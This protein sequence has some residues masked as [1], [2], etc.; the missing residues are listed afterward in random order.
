M[1]NRCDESQGKNGNGP[2]SLHQLLFLMC[3]CSHHYDIW[4]SYYGNHYS[5]PLGHPSSSQQ[6]CMQPAIETSSTYSTDDH[7]AL[8]DNEDPLSFVGLSNSSSTSLI[9]SPIQQKQQWH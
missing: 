9:P 5:P 6:P 8:M 2:L 4:D 1:F 7:D 3:C